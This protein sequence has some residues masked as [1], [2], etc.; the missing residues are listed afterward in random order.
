MGVFLL[1]SKS[2]NSF[3]SDNS[4]KI[5]GE[6]G[7]NDPKALD[8]GD[9]NAWV[10]NKT[11]TGEDQYLTRE[12]NVLICAGTPIYAGS[13][14]LNESLEKIM[15]ELIRGTFDFDSVRGCYS[16]IFS[17]PG[18]DLQLLTDQSGIHNI[19][20]TSDHSV[21]STSFLGIAIGLEN[22]ISLN[23]MAI[24]EVLTT[25]RLMGPDTLINEINRFEIDLHDSLGKIRV[26]NNREE[27]DGRQKRNYDE[28]VENQ[29]A[30]VDSYFKDIKPFGENYGVDTGITGGHDSRMMLAFLRNH[31]NNFQIH[32]FWRKEKDVELSVA[33]KVAEQADLELKIVK[34]KHHFDLSEEEMKDTLRESLLFY[35]G[36]I[37]M[38]CFLME[39]YN[40]RAH[41]QDILGDVR[42]GMN[43][44]GGEQYRNE[45]HIE[46]KSWSKNYFTRF[47]LG[48]HLSGR[49]FTSSDFEDQYFEYLE[50]KVS[51]LVGSPQSARS[52]NRRE[53]QK[54][55][56]E[57]YVR[58]L[59]G[60]RTNAENK[61]SHFITP[62]L[63]Y[64]LTQN[65]YD[66]L[67][68]HGISFSFQQSM[69]RHVDKDLSS[70]ISGYGY[71]FIDGEPL[72][73]KIK[74]LIKE[75][76]PK[77]IYQDRLDK[78]MAAKGTKDLER[79]ESQFEVIARSL[80]VLRSLDL[81]IDESTI[82]CRPDLMPVYISMG[83]LLLF[84]QERGRLNHEG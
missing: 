25:G 57:V 64:Q 80:S 7:L 43:G 10:W 14:T 5:I 56:N 78:K 79:F 75:Y 34:A 50:S 83:Y 20:F 12:G 32:S 6:M 65:S 23:T 45:W 2:D 40:T 47:F 30:V 33:E 58:S 42:L 46:R 76:T 84:L 49:C 27:P 16:L 8:L 1:Q 4:A 41:R 70:V 39:Q 63:D 55:L 11:L 19:Y 82:V 17:K 72:K 15:D 37:R 24:T 68:H 67:P 38:H 22:S 36:H 73:N 9:Y 21:I 28:E 18:Q 54:Y 52:L 31:V 59:M 81:P 74:Y 26:V 62:Y 29:V 35:D 13:K 51:K 44:I 3:N 61:L 60:A 71:N 66:S 69:L 48:Y 77:S 53:M